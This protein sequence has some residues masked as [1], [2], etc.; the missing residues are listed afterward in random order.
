MITLPITHRTAYTLLRTLHAGIAM[1]GGKH[2]Q[3]ERCIKPFIDTCDL[4][5]DNT[6]D[7]REWCRCLKNDG[8]VSNEDRFLKKGPIVYD[9]TNF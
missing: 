3:N 6:I 1:T 4:D 8:M 2:D 7:P 9:K 5:Q